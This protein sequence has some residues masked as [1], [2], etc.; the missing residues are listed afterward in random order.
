M[1]RRRG[2]VL[3]SG[4]RD[5]PFSRVLPAWPAVRALAALRDWVRQLAVLERSR[6][7]RAWVLAARA[8]REFGALRPEGSGKAS[9]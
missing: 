4:A 2:W 7:F 8:R 6:A 9:R 3:R 5:G 1:R